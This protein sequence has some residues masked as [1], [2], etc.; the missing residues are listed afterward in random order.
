MALYSK[1]KRMTIPD[2]A[3]ITLVFK[4]AYPEVER[5]ALTVYLARNGFKSVGESLQ[6][7]FGVE[8]SK[9]S[10]TK[11][12]GS[13]NRLLRISGNTA[14]QIQSK[15]D[16]VRQTLGTDLDWFQQYCYR[17]GLSTNF[18]AS[19]VF[20]K[21]AENLLDYCT[22]LFH[23]TY[24]IESLVAYIGPNKMRI[25]QAMRN[26]DS[27]TVVAEISSISNA[28]KE[29]FN[30]VSTETALARVWEVKNHYF[31][32]ASN[33]DAVVELTLDLLENS[34]YDEGLPVEFKPEGLRI[35]LEASAR[36]RSAKKASKL[37]RVT[38][39]DTEPKPDLLSIPEE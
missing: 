12:K 31:T 21:G 22:R 33:Q 34:L 11:G 2:W 19:E 37:N 9:R 16:I 13:F 8:Q 30:N 36:D 3:T 26:V 17:C 39:T 20:D 18:K 28:W 23:D 15:A 5:D 32:R 6:D 4:N 27:A 1:K 29:V 38:S 25:R 14:R 10:G 35:L 24:K 7:A